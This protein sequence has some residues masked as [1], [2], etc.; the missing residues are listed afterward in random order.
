[1]KQLAIL[2]ATGS[3]GASTLAVIDLHPDL[4]KIFALSADKNWQKMSLL[5]Q[6]YQ[7]R[8]ALMKNNAAAKSLQKTLKEKGCAQTEVLYGDEELCNIVTHEDLNYV[9]AAIVGSAGMRSA[10]AS[11]KAD[12]R[13][14]LANKEAL[15]LSG[16]LLMQTLQRSKAELLPVDSEHSAI[17]QCLES[18][19]LGL[20]KIQLTASGGP[21]LNT[22]YAKL[23]HITP[24][25]ACAHP[26]WQMGRKISIDSATMINKGLE[27]IEAHYLFGLSSDSI[28][29]IVHPQSLMHS[30]VFY[31]DGSS[32]AQLSLPDMR[33]AITYA[34]SYP[35]RINSG[36][37]DL[38]LSAHTPL[39]FYKPNLKQFP[40]LRLSIEALKQGGSAMATLSSANEVAVHGFLNREIGFLDIA[41]IIEKTLEK[42]PVCRLDCL[43]SIVQNDKESRI[44]ARKIMRNISQ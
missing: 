25:E 10:L 28:E 17:F 39:E 8:F 41:V 43:E 32:L 40:C 18:G 21:F 37:V 20:K 15:I 44:L 34:L 42:K 13:L 23:K 22:P 33:T 14:L 35:D 2:G 29:V 6:R 9:M 7:P 30:Q 12:K 26:N 5:C 3:I 11:I 24:D 4:F 27:M 38:D 36:V 1:M 16:D 19:K 31:E